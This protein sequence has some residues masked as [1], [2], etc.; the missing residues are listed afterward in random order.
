LGLLMVF[1]RID[2][3]VARWMMCGKLRQLPR[4]C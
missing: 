3:S 1:D 4:L 2:Q